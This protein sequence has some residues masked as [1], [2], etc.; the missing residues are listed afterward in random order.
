MTAMDDVPARDAGLASG[1][2][3]VS[4]QLSAAIGL[5]ALGTIAT[6]RT[7]ALAA[8]GQ[9][10]VDALSGGYHL[11]FLI[12]AGAAAVGI[13]I[14]ILV[15]RSPRPELEAVEGEREPVEVAPEAEAQA[16]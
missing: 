11:A 14:A 12:A 15:L 2:I 13:A 1:T 16:A 3:Q 9:S 7:N 5:A 6:D 10:A 4:I 8:H